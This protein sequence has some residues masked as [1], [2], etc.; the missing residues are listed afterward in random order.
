MYGYKKIEWIRNYK[1][2]W[3]SADGVYTIDKLDAI[4]YACGKKNFVIENGF[5]VFNDIISCQAYSTLVKAK[6]W[7]DKECEK[8]Y[9]HSLQL[10][11]NQTNRYGS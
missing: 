6:K 8:D 9:L 11:I 4:T 10:E 2:T 7:C 3:K 5:K 1:N